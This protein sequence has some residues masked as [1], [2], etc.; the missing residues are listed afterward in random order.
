MSTKQ[1]EIA[2]IALGGN[3]SAEIGSVRAVIEGAIASVAALSADPQAVR[4]SRLFRT[5]AFPEGAGPDFVNAAMAFP[6]AGTAQDLLAELHAIEAEAGR[7]RQIRWGARVLDLDLIALGGQVLPDA[8]TQDGW[9]AL[10]LAVQQTRA[11]E[12][13]ILPHPR[14]QDRSFVL[15]PLAEVAPGWRHP[16]IGRTVEE[17]LADRPAQERAEVQPLQ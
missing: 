13:L 15:V 14:V 17:L 1:G 16:R 7:E 5:P 4:T 9:R 6:Y 3:G 11:P 8:G 2:L 12:R 10:P